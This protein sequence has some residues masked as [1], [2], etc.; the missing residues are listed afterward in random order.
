LWYNLSGQS[1]AVQSQCEPT[2]YK[3]FRDEGLDVQI[4]SVYLNSEEQ[5]RGTIDSRMQMLLDSCSWWK[6]SVILVYDDVATDALLRSNMNIVYDTP[7]IFA[8]VNFPDWSLIEKFKNVTGYTSTPEYMKAADMANELF[9][10]QNISFW[11]NQ[12]E[13][14]TD[15]YPCTV[16]GSE[17]RTADLSDLQFR[18]VDALSACDGTDLCFGS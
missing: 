14:G 7:V 12:G 15:A 10:P 1:Y 2:L 16:D 9:H 8:G 6:P 4:H 11:M 17:I 18:T 5:A 3:T 13:G